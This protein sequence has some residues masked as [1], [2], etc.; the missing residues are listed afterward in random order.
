MHKLEQ[1]QGQHNSRTADGGVNSHGKAREKLG[2]E[3]VD[4]HGE[5]E[6]LPD[7]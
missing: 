1:Q 3:G 2:H 4:L 5:G 6:G 7:L